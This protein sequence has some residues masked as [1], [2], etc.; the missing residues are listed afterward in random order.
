MR[1]D[2]RGTGFG[3]AESAHEEY[4]FTSRYDSFAIRGC[5]CS[6]LFAHPLKVTDR[7][8]WNNRPARQSYVEGMGVLKPGVPGAEWLWYISRIPYLC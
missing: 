4:S 7:G 6:S 2:G 3:C 5:V 8:V 1:W